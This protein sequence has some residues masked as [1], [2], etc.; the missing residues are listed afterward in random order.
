MDYSMC[1]ITELRYLNCKDKLISI[2]K[3]KPFDLYF[4]V[5][6]VDQK[7]PFAAGSRHF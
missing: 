2:Y 7:S 6:E 4:W 1:A 5:G 3:I